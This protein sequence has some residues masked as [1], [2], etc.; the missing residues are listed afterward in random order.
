MDIQVKEFLDCPIRSVEPV[1]KV[2][3]ETDI[4]VKSHFEMFQSDQLIWI[5]MV[6]VFV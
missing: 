1:I 3:L 2:K 4:K 6:K 5:I